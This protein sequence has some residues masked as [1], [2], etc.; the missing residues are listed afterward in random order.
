M[1]FLLDYLASGFLNMFEL[2]QQC[3]DKTSN[4]SKQRHQKTNFSQSP[5]FHAKPNIGGRSSRLVLGDYRLLHCC[6]CTRH[7]LLRP[8][9]TTFCCK[10]QN[11]FFREKKPLCQK[12]LLWFWGTLLIIVSQKILASQGAHEPKWSED[13]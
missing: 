4:Q 9:T 10:K 13:D 5:E 12:F 1:K 11:N 6:V 3:N 8:L 7:P 2:E